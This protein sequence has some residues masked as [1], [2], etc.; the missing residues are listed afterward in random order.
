MP[1]QVRVTHNG[2]SVDIIDSNAVKDYISAKLY[3]DLRPQKI[4]DFKDGKVRVI[5]YKYYT[6]YQE[7]FVIEELSY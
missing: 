5:I 2:Y 3:P 6:L 4:V 1:K 7:V